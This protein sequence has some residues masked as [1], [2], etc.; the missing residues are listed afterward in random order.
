MAPKKYTHGLG[1]H[2]YRVCLQQTDSVGLHWH[3]FYEMELVLSGN[4]IHTVNGQERPWKR[5]CIH[6]MRL[7]D[8]HSIET[9]KST[10]FLIQIDA[11]SMPEEILKKLGLRRGTLATCMEEEKLQEMEL[12]FRLLL[13]EKDP[14]LRDALLRVILLFFLQLIDL[15]EEKTDGDQRLEEILLYIGTH[16]REELTP[17]L[18]AEQFYM[19]K[20]YFCTYFKKQTGKTV[21][22]YINNLRLEYAAEL[23]VASDLC[24]N[25]MME[26]AGFG[27]VSQFLR[28]F[29][30]KFGVTPMKMRKGARSAF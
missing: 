28:C 10:V 8:L 9:E 5:G 6:L 24:T 22:E 4:G 17:A 26:A 16:F 12:L 3:D 29:K 30:K 1:S 18:L 23:A 7:S 21:V 14:A 2:G 13:R 15:P 27:S 25:S 19:S 20:S 11:G